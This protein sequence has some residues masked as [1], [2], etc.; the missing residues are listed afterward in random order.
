[1]NK[2]DVGE[3]ALE[4]G[5][6]YTPQVVD[7]QGR[8]IIDGPPVCNIIP[9]VGI[10]HLVS[11]L[12]GSGSLI[13]NWYVGVYEGNY[14]PTSAT[15]SADLPSNALESVAYSETS[16]PLWNNTY[17]GVSVISNLST[18]AEFTFTSDKRLYGG[19]LVSNS[20]KGGGSGTL[21]SIARFSSPYDVPSGSTFRLGVSIALIPSL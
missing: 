3:G 10:D 13:S 20:V 11:L 6:V 12:R 8:V 17:D 16:R 1:M 15:T 5:F 4:L 7:P 2:L 9:Q 19:F 14:V 21:L 18:R